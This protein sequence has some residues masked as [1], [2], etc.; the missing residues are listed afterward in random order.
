MRTKVTDASGA[1]LPATN[2]LSR[3]FSPLHLLLLLPSFL[4]PSPPKRTSPESTHPFSLLRL[5][6]AIPE[7]PKLVAIPSRQSVSRLSAN[8]SL[9]QGRQKEKSQ[10]QNKTRT[11]LTPASAFLPSPEGTGKTQ[12]P[13]HPRVSPHARVGVGVGG[14]GGWEWW[15]KNGGDGGGGSNSWTYRDKGRDAAAGTRGY[16]SPVLFGHLLSG[17]QDRM[18]AEDA[19]CRRRWGSGGGGLWRPRR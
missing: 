13:P 4:P 10:F 3:Q 2:W 17:C 12:K 9:S 14:G 19:P 11:K 5:R 8:A 1:R 6:H 15:C 7:A 16:L 18:R